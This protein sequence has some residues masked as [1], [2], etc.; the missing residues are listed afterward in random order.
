M[1]K[2]LK[3]INIGILT[4]GFN[5]VNDDEVSNKVYEAIDLLQKEGKVNNI[6][7]NICSIM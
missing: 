6:K 4:E 2:N 3:K 7:K 1:M 5:L